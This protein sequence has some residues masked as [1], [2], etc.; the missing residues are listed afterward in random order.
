MQYVIIVYT[1]IAVLTWL[2]IAY[3]EWRDVIE[4]DTSLA[5]IM[6]KWA[7]AVLGALLWPIMAA[8]WLYGMV[9]YG[10]NLFAGKW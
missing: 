6:G 4:A 2:F 9:R 8:F 10:E 1:V 7:I 3:P 5:A